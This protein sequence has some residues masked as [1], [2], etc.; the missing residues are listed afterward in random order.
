MP[1]INGRAFQH[2]DGIHCYVDGKSE[3][4]VENIINCDFNLGKRFKIVWAQAR[5]VSKTW[6]PEE[7]LTH[8]GRKLREFLCRLRILEETKN[9][10]VDALN[11]IDLTDRRGGKDV[12]KKKKS[13][14][15][16]KKKSKK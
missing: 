14:K 10:S 8:C 4:V 13:A 3:W 2:L 9:F 5:K 6:E 1:L 11:D 12:P 7:N 16:R 15:N